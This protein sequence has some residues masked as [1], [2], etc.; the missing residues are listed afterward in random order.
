VA[1]SPSS[2]TATQICALL[3]KPTKRSARVFVTRH[4]SA[5]AIRRSII[6]TDTIADACERRAID[7]TK[8]AARADLG[9][10]F[11]SLHQYVPRIQEGNEVDELA[12]SHVVDVGHRHRRVQR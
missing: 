1:I 11:V 8:N 2:C 9:G 10:R 12:H 3:P 5:I 7:Q 4:C 6:A